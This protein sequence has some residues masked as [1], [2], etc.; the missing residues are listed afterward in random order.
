[1]ALKEGY[2]E[3]D[4]KP[5]LVTVLQTIYCH[6]APVTRIVTDG[7]TIWETHDPILPEA[8]YFENTWI[9]MSN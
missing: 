4:G 7:T 9:P 8:S 5:M 3:I 2:I 6:D 1:M